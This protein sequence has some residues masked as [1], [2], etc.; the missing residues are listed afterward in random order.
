M[1]IFKDM[2]KVSIAISLICCL[3]CGCASRDHNSNREINIDFSEVDV[4]SIPFSQIM[5]SVSYLALELPDSIVVGRVKDISFEDSMIVILDRYTDGLI[6][7]SRD[8]K[9]IGLM[10]SK[11]NGPGEYISADAICTDRNYVYLY[12]R[13]QRSVIRYDHY[14]NYIGKDS[15]GDAEDFVKID[16]DGQT[17]YLSALYNATP[18]KSG[19]YLWNQAEGLRKLRGCL[20]DTPCNHTWVIFQDNEKSSVMTRNYEN[21][22]FNPDGDSLR[23]E[24]DL[25]ITPQPTRRELDN[26]NPRNMQNHLTRGYYYNTDRWFICDNWMG[27][28][29]YTVIID[30]KTGETLRTHGLYNDFDSTVAVQGLPVAVDNALVFIDSTDEDNLR[31]QFR[32]LKS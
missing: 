16:I 9:F 12:D 15:I 26:W 30:K 25:R 11:G 27:N 32:H 3:L 29:L 20:D 24:L 31:L 4:D 23:L 5:D 1:Q 6:K 21:R 2:R 10:G 14:G 19:I 18:E 7:L 17:H 13:M 28:D 22:V 8:G